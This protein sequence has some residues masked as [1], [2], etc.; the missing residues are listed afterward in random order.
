M[1]MIPGEDA[2]VAAVHAI[3]DRLRGEAGAS[4]WNEV[5]AVRFCAADGA[6]LRHDLAQV[7]T[8]LGVT[9]LPRLWIG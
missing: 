4:S 1:L 2:V 9:P 7:L 5:A 3:G 6:A 8:A